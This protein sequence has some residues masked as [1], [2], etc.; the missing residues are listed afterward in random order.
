MKGWL[1]AAAPF[2]EYAANSATAAIQ[3]WQFAQYVGGFPLKSLKR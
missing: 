3:C 1:L 2:A